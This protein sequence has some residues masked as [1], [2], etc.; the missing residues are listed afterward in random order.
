MLLFCYRFLRTEMFAKNVAENF[1]VERC[2]KTSESTESTST[3]REVDSRR[4]S[5][6]EMEN[7][8]SDISIQSEED[9]NSEDELEK[10]NAEKDD[11][12]LGNT[13]EIK[14]ILF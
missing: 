5:D 9:C 3:R 11:D 2:R 12:I 7:F 1:T 10:L 6:Y 4:N 14:F 8:D 13:L